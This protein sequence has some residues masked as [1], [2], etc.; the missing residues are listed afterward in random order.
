MHHPMKHG[1]YTVSSGY[2]PRWGT[3]HNGVDF[4]AP[5]GTPIYAPADGIVV[6][7][8]DRAQGSVDGFGSWIWIDSQQSAGLDFIFGHVHHP[9]ILVK[10]GD[11]VKAGQQIG[12]VGNEGQSTGPHL[13]F[14]TW[15][16]PGRQGGPHRNPDDFLARTT[17]PGGTPEK[18]TAPVA[19]TPLTVV[20]Y[21]GGIPAAAAIRAAGH[22][23]AVRYISDDRTGGGLP[24]KPFKPEEA[25][26]FKAA[27]L[28]VAVVWQ[29]G[30]DTAAAPPD[31]MRGREGGLA[32]AREADKRLDALGM[33]GW[34]VFFAVDFD[35]Q[36]TEW[37]T[38]VEYLRAAC[39]VLGRDR[40]GIYGGHNACEWAL[41]DKV[42]GDAGD[43][44]ALL[45]QTRSWSGSK[46][47]PAAVLYQR[48][49][50]TKATPGP[51][52]G[53]VTVDVNDVLHPNWGQH[54]PRPADVSHDMPTT[55]PPAPAAPTPA[56]PAQDPKQQYK[57]D[58]DLLTWR[59]NG[60]SRQK[61]IAVIIHT[62]ES[63]YNYATGK[64][65]DTAWT[66]DQLA[67]YNRGG[68]RSASRGSYHI[69][70]DRAAR[71]VRQ[72]D[73]QY[74]TWST[75]NKANDNA[76]HV[77]LTGTAYQSREQWMNNMPQLRRAA[78]IVAHWCRKD[79]IRVERL[80]PA[81]LSSGKG[82]IGGHWDTSKAYGGSDHWDP[83]GYAG[84][85]PPKTA[86]GFPWDVF[87][88]L[89]KKATEQPTGSTPPAPT[90]PPAP[91]TPTAPA[92]PKPLT[93][94]ETV[95]LILDQL[96]GP[97]DGNGSQAFKGWPQLGGLTLVDAVAKIG[98]HNNL[99]GFIDPTN[100]K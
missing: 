35:I 57:C 40:V 58:A 7:G 98:A 95:A 88:D 55:P 12:V 97:R 48:V 90:A 96:C 77:C 1:T 86:G 66:A 79:G 83:G 87:V 36:R 91:S 19:N 10:R 17:S 99:D 41:A 82:G 50:D 38:A 39:E 75:G 47:H 56:R 61:R 24:G 42:V 16:A 69:G 33:R 93:A 31:V 59:D 8:K 81:D 28:D 60:I 62:D 89:V 6:Q 63:G 85:T 67:E 23:G 94:E 5:Q 71:A 4:A 11:R 53:G 44:K 52:V 2:G 45:W 54:A 51:K 84:P 32:D 64:Q 74:G 18:E 3:H 65:R 9:G 13:H 80:S 21:A 72:N 37:A 43:G 100:N 25:A 70:V 49:V 73:D 15:G 34:P 46:I 76:Y 27:G 26:A 14:E 20:D 29:Y 22:V 92:P 78:E 68:G 30:K